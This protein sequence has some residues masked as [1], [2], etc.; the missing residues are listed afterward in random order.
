MRRHAA[1]NP[2]TGR[3]LRIPFALVL[4]E[5]SYQASYTVTYIPKSFWGSRFLGPPSSQKTT[6]EA[7]SRTGV[8]RDA[9]AKVAV[10]A[11]ARL[12]TVQVRGAAETREVVPAAAAQDTVTARCSIA[13]I[14]GRTY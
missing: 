11:V 14:T 7:R 2:L 1:Q 6:T 12:A 4:G 5:V 8:K 3:N 9:E 13:W 10:A